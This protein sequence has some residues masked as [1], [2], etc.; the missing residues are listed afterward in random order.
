[1]LTKSNSFKLVKLSS[2]VSRISG[3]EE[4]RKVAANENGDAVEDRG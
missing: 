1:M 2:L 3:G 4:E